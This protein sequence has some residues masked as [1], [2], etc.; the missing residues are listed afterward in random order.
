MVLDG[1]VQ[2]RVSDGGIVDFAVTMAAIADQVYDHVA[3]VNITVFDGE[4]SD[5]NH[6]IHIFGVDVKDRDGLPPC[7]LRGKTRRV[8]LVVQRGK[9]EQIVGD[10]VDGAAYGVA[11]QV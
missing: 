11:L 10:D 1:P 9:A 6:G 5:P 8:F 4:S 7:Q 2:E 3:L